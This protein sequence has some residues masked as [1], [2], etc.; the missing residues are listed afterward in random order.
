VK[1]EKLW[2]RSLA[3]LLALCRAIEADPANRNPPG[4]FWLYVPKAR[5]QL[6]RIARA[7]ADQVRERRQA[8]GER[9][10]QSG[11]SGRQ[12]KRR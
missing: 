5:R 10:D 9:L 8:R 11:Y 3:E 7:I 6:D 1:Q 2:N 4:S 12:S